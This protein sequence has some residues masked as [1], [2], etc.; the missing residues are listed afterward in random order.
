M[1]PKPHFVLDTNVV[2]S[3]VLLKNSASYKAFVKAYQQGVLLLSWPIV[4][5]LSEVLK[6]TKFDKYV[7]LEQ[8]MSFLATLV[9]AATLIEITQTITD[10][11]DPKDNMFLELAITGQAECIISGDKDLLEL[12]P[13][14][15]VSILR[16]DAFLAT[17]QPES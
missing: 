12:H 1:K 11:R 9:S 10:C 4:D 3:A 13:F 8:R 7:S 6:R 17:Y 16:P 2:V 15:G 5:E 14:Q